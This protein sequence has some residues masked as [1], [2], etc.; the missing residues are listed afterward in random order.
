MKKIFWTLFFIGIFL[1]NLKMIDVSAV[2]YNRPVSQMTPQEILAELRVATAETQE[3]RYYPDSR[4]VELNKGLQD[5]QRELLEEYEKKLKRDLDR[6]KEYERRQEILLSAI[7]E[8]AKERGQEWYKKRKEQLQKDA[9]EATKRSLGITDAEVNEL[10]YQVARGRDKYETEYKSYVETA[11]KL[12]SIYNAYEE[13]RNKYREA[14]DEAQNLLGNLTLIGEGLNTVAGKLE[15]SQVGRPVAEILKFYAEATKVGDRAA[16]AAMNAIHQDGISPLHPTQYTDGLAE[17]A[18]QTGRQ[19]FDRL[20]RTSLMTNDENLRILRAE[21][22]YIIFDKDFNYIG[23]ASQEEYNKMEMIYA[24]FEKARREGN[25]YSK[26]NGRWGNLTSEQLLKLS[27]GEAVELVNHQRWFRSDLTQEMTIDDLYEVF[28]WNMRS[29]Q[30]E[31]SRQALYEALYGDT[32]EDPEASGV[33]NSISSI[34]GGDTKSKRTE[35]L[36]EAFNEYYKTLSLDDLYDLDS[37]STRF[38]NEA[39]H[40]EQFLNVVLENKSNGK[41]VKELINYFRE[42][43]KDG[44]QEVSEDSKPNIDDEELVSV[45]YSD[46]FGFGDINDF[47]NGFQNDVTEFMAEMLNHWMNL[48][49]EMELYPLTGTVIDAETGDPI[50]GASITISRATGFNCAPVNSAQDG[51]FSVGQYGVGEVLTVKA[52]AKGYFPSKRIGSLKGSHTRVTIALQKED[53]E[54]EEDNE[55]DKTIRNSIVILIDVSG[56]M[57]GSKIEN[58]RRSAISTIDRLGNSD[59][60]AVI[61][62]SSCNRQPSIIIPFTRASS[63]NKESMK[64]TVG[65]IRAG[66]GTALAAATEFAGNYLNSNA[67]S[68]SRNLIILSDGEETCGGDPVGAVRNMN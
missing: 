66:G 19:P 46:S 48:M 47:V 43:Q 60:I 16:G 2:S 18:R 42:M 30:R 28:D 67:R 62:F 65:G 53:L 24:G 61:T 34:W 35:E 51:S 49:G 39:H 15:K 41:S 56:S 9:L 26:I 6:M 12:Y 20:D 11:K 33:W 36:E 52:S 58:A 38:Y 8:E 14:P 55:S 25:R 1:L 31:H 54:D 59:E 29:E 45:E 27:R 13:A 7:K 5:G 44:E 4:I 64:Q 3:G 50:N 21:D 32:Y 37:G 57:S 68:S 40:R 22:D 10:K 23:Y 17:F 63:Q